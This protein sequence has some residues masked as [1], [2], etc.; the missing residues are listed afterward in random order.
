MIIVCF[1]TNRLGRQYRTRS[2]RFECAV[3]SGSALFAI[4]SATFICITLNHIVQILR[5]LQQF[6]GVF[7]F[8]RFFKVIT[9]LQKTSKAPRGKRKGVE[10]G[11]GE[12]LTEVEPSQERRAGRKR[13]GTGSQLQQE[14]PKKLRRRKKGQ[15]SSLTNSVLSERETATQSISELKSDIVMDSQYV[16]RGRMKSILNKGDNHVK[17]PAARTKTRARLSSN[18]DDN[19]SAAVKSRRNRTKAT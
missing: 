4:L 2:E 18:K 10:K 13:V 5:L 16:T 12:E 14:P 11:G 9:F 8:L 3:W 6:F 17:S 19:K 1:W 15:E 7:Q